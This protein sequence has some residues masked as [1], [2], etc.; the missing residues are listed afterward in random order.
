[1]CH[2]AKVPNYPLTNDATLQYAEPGAAS[3]HVKQRERAM[4]ASTQAVASTASNANKQ[5][6][7]C[8]QCKQSKQAGKQAVIGLFTRYRRSICKIVCVCLVHLRPSETV[9]KGLLG[10]PFQS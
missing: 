10:A 1:M 9:D 2:I 4:P 5:S 8:E 6:E 7:Q 3:K